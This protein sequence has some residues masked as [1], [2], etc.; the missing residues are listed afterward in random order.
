MTLRIEIGEL[1]PG[2]WGACSAGGWESACNERLGVV[3][4]GVV[5][6]YELDARRVTAATT[7]ATRSRCARSSA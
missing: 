1:V 2:P 3:G 4:D 5:H 7:S 6:A